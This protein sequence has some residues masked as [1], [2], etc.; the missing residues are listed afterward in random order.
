MQHPQRNCVPNA[1]H[2]TPADKRKGGH[3]GLLSDSE[4]SP[5]ALDSVEEQHPLII[6]H[7]LITV[8]M[9]GFTENSS[10]HLVRYCFLQYPFFGHRGTSLWSG[11]RG[12]LPPPGPSLYHSIIVPLCPCE[13]KF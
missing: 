7:Q 6:T 12:V 3:L 4:L 2:N 1:P 8:A 5:Q 13:A 10:P 9:G 11:P